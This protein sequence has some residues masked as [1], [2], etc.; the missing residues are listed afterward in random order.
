MKKLVAL[1]LALVMVLG[2]VACAQTNTGDAEIPDSQP[3][4]TEATTEGKTALKSFTV[5]VVYA[6]GTSKDFHYES[7]EEFVGPVLQAEGLIEG[8]MG[9]YGLEISHVDGVKAVYAEDGAYW[10]IYEGDQYAMSG[11]DGIK[12]TDGGSYTL[13]YERG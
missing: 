3:S 11:I 4:G 9:P 5:T 2:L 7:D 13:K 8:K 10:A 6:D 1:L 12:V